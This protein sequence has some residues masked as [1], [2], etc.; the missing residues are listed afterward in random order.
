MRTMYAGGLWQKKLLSFPF[1]C[2]RAFEPL[3]VYPIAL[4]DSHLTLSHTSGFFML[5]MT[6]LA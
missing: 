3:V 1:G 5:L 4:H 2:I 6:V